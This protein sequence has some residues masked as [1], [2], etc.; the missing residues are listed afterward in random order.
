MSL[1]ICQSDNKSLAKPAL[2]LALWALLF[3]FE[4]LCL[5]FNYKDNQ[6]Y[7]AMQSF[8]RGTGSFLS[9]FP[10]IS[11]QQFHQASL[12]ATGNLAFIWFALWLT[13]KHEKKFFSVNRWLLSSSDRWFLGVLC[14][15]A[16][17]LYVFRLHFS[18]QDF[19]ISGDEHSFLFQAKLLSQGR[20][21]AP[22]HPLQEF[23]NSDW[24]VNKER[25]HSIYPPGNAYFLALGESFGAPWIIPPLLGAA[26][27]P[28]LYM[29][30]RKAFGQELARFGVCFVSLCPLVVA[31]N[32]SYFAH[33]GE[34][35][36]LSIFIYS[37]LKT[38]EKPKLSWPFLSGIALGIAINI[39]PQTAGIF[40]L[41]FAFWGLR[42]LI[43]H[44]KETSK[45]IAVFALGLAIPLALLLITNKLQTGHPL[46]LGY[47]AYW[48]AEG[49]TPTISA[50][51]LS[52]KKNVANRFTRGLGDLA[53]R[54]RVLIKHLKYNVFSGLIFLTGI[55]LAFWKRNK[56][57]YLFGSLFV[58]MIIAYLFLGGNIWQ[59]RYY[60]EALVCLLLL[61]PVGLLQLVRLWKKGTQES[62]FP[63]LTIFLG[64]VIAVTLGL[65]VKRGF[66]PSSY[67]L[68][69]RQPYDTVEKAG[70]K[71][72]LIF[73]RNVKLFYPK[74]YTR[75]S[76]DLSGGVL[77]VL[78]LGDR[79]KEL[80]DF[81]PQ[82]EYYIYDQGKLERISK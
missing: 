61:I 1:E 65:N 76:P 22:A 58:L 36:F 10:A 5:A 27:L 70:I 7:T 33:A 2:S 18:L 16:F 68:Q 80:M 46:R 79:N 34:M 74:W 75:N 78:H 40:S 42:H 51:F 55:I 72:A 41:P 31:I 24:I 73:I 53:F 63:F 20:L 25:I 67:M 13:T 32:G 11:Y 71:N 23:F 64:A 82:K 57:T 26:T 56:Y 38:L 9:L 30:A 12:T 50:R 3:G 59:V 39:R 15:S 8:Y 17:A 66:S 47:H 45:K 48:E 44:P 28:F 14:L 49:G 29:I 60:Y 69:L 52:S 37:F 43:R 77:Y 6:A 62:C 19:P 21:W 4:L 81:Y 35:L 54:I